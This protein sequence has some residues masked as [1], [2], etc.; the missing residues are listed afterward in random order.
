MFSYVQFRSIG[1]NRRLAQWR[2]KWLI[3]HSTSHQLLWCIESF[4]LRNPPLRQAPKRYPFDF[5]WD[6]KPAPMHRIEKK[7]INHRVGAM[8]K[9]LK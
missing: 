5:V 2:V 1:A 3:E 7:P 8:I 4:V 6:E 9:R